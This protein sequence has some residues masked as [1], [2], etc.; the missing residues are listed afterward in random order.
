MK[1]TPHK[2][3]DGALEKLGAASSRWVEAEIEVRIGLIDRLMEDLANS[4]EEWVAESL[5]AKQIA[6]STAGTA[7][8]WLGGPYVVMRNLRLLRLSLCHIRDT[9][10]PVIPGPVSIRPNG[11]VVASVFPVDKYDALLFKGTSAEVWMLPDVNRDQLEETMAVAYAAPIA[12]QVCLVLGGG[13]VSSI[14]PMDCFYKLFVEK[15]VTLLKMHPVNEYLG[16]V[17]CRAFAALI[18]QGYLEIVY[19]GA[20]EGTYLCSHSGVDE[21]HITGSD[22]THDLIAFGKD[23]A[24][25]K[26]AQ[27]PLLDKPI[28]SELGNVSPVI[29]V[30]GTW[31]E[32]DIAFQADNV[33]SSLVN[34]AGFNCNA[35]R[36]LIMQRDWP[37][38]PAFLE[39]IRQRLA[40][41]PT[42]AA[43]YPG[44]GE[45]FDAF[46]A[47]HPEGNYFGERQGNHLPW[48]LIENLDSTAETDICF[49]TEAFCGLCGEMPLDATTAEDFI[50]QAVA[51]ANDKLWG[52]LNAT[53]LAH[54]TTMT[55]SGRAIDR[56]IADLRYGTVSL[57]HWAAVGYGV[58]TTPWGAFPGHDF[59]DIQS[60][61]DVV[62]NTLMFDKPQKAVIRGPFRVS[63]KPAWFAS[64]KK[65]DVVGRRIT[66]FEAKPSLF[67]LPAIVLP[68]LLG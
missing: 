57:N 34:N 29:V 28:T 45:R 54:P 20:A 50:D 24:A 61:R 53:I 48:M 51:F 49:S 16:P 26:A 42:R 7:Q 3:L 65:A 37:Q 60:G 22:K 4:A 36:L 44:A 52:T 47:A 14:G 12:G 41:V 9:G 25:Q 30:P 55:E 63:P 64:H 46:A 23:P 58:C 40:G 8:E 43:Y 66:Y 67:K 33:V 62:H 32:K 27:K 6:G 2:A 17:F 1:M 11:Q 56:A 68:A 38:R 39:A 18:E 35:S 10:K 5:R 13:N 19:G 31:R 59:Y 21:I 15:K